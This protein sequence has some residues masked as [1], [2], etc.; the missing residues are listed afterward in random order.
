MKILLKVHKVWEVVENESNETDKDD[1]ATALL[2][3]SIPETLILQVGDL[4]TAKKVWD[5]IKARHV[6]ADR[7]RKAR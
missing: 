1:M 4:D 2:L 7:V 6:G 5:A 3:Q